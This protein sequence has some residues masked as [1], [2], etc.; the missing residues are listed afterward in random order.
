[1]AE[2]F[3]CPDVN[4]LEQFLLGQLHEAQADPLGEHLVQCLHCL[5]AVAALEADGGD[6]VVRALRAVGAAE[7]SDKAMVASLIDR[8]R[9]QQRLAAG[10]GPDPTGLD[11]VVRAPVEMGWPVVEGY[12]ILAELGRGG[13]GV[14]YKARQTTL[15]RLVALKM[16]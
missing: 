11:L 10:S 16:I 8:V 6:S 4:D 12:E 1:M 7:T 13:M 2:I 14:V 9:E 3:P 15:Q 5:A